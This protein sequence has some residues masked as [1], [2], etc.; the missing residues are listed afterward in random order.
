MG[1]SRH[2]FLLFM[3][4]LS[5]IIS[6]A[7]S[8]TTTTDRKQIVI[9]E[10]FLYTVEATFPAAGY[11][12]HWFNVPDSFAH[13]E[14]I[15]RGKRDSV[16]TD[17]NLT[18]RQTL[19]LT[20]FDSGVNVIPSFPVT[21]D[22]AAGDGSTTLQTDSI[23]MTVAFSPL[24]SVKTFHDIKT[25]LDVKEPFDYQKWI[26][27]AAGVLL[28]ILLIFLLYKYLKKKKK[29]KDMFSGKLSPYDEAIT[30][31]EAL[32]E[33]KLLENNE[34]KRFHT[35][36]S[37]IFK[38]YLSRQTHKDLFNQTTT[39]LLLV[40]QENHLRKETIATTANILGM[41]DGVKFAKYAPVR[42]DSEESRQQLIQT[43]KQIHETATPEQPQ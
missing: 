5:G 18:C 3:L 39:G 9:G 27:I 28:F 22:P 36:M 15:D 40:M 23:S 37:D 8:I 35:S 12:A 16:T 43:I 14:V 6:N 2:S 30:A 29:G 24:D 4:L 33:Q 20:S 26:M 34:V 10:Q 13:F 21:F 31:L 17:G 19:V 11:T 32:L 42:A 1:N 7:Q 25:V 41:A 38:R